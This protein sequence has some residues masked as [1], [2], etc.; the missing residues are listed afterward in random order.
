MTIIG[1]KVLFKKSE[2]LRQIPTVSCSTTEFEAMQAKGLYNFRT[3]DDNG[4]IDT[5]DVFVNSKLRVIGCSLR[6]VGGFFT[7][8]WNTDAFLVRTKYVIDTGINAQVRVLG[9]ITVVDQQTPQGKNYLYAPSKSSKKILS[10]NSPTFYDDWV[11]WFNNYKKGI[12][13]SM[14]QIGSPLIFS[15]DI[16]PSRRLDVEITDKYY[17]IAF[18][19][20]K[21][22]INIT[23][24]S[25]EDNISFCSPDSCHR[26]S[27][28][29]RYVIRP[30]KSSFLGE[31][32][33]KFYE[34]VKITLLK[35]DYYVWAPIKIIYLQVSN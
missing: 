21:E 27:M 18:P 3:N 11:T 34:L 23:D 28:K 25:K 24:E 33:P 29:E 8:Q 2:Q 1:D 4:F 16:A 6:S 5:E 32:D 9:V 14:P 31:G 13:G 15:G 19:A 26:N 17:S 35:K 30:Q 10:V 7:K 22:E 20:N 12:T